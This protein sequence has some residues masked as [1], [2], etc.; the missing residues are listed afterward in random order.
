MT[1]Q[2]T[3]R[4]T[5]G[6]ICFFS[7][8]YAPS[9][10]AQ[11]NGEEPGWEEMMLN[12]DYNFFEIQDAFNKAWDGKPY[13]S[14]NGYK[15]FKRWEYWI[16]TLVDENG[17][18]DEMKTR[19]E[20]ENYLKTHPQNE[21]KSSLTCAN[22]NA[23]GNWTALGPFV[24]PLGNNGIGRVNVVGF[25][26][27]NNNHIWAGTPAGGL[28]EST[29]GGTT[30]TT[31]TDDFQ[32]LGVSDIAIHPTNPD[33]MYI[34]TGDNDHSDTYAFGLLKSIDA[35][36][37]WTTTSLNVGN[38]NLMHRLLMN[39]DDPDVLLV[40]TSNTV[41]KSTDAG[42]TWTN[43]MSDY[44]RHMEFKPG[45]PNIV[46]AT[47]YADGLFFR[48]TDCGSTWTMTSL[49]ASAVDVERFG[50]GV[51]ADDANS[52]F[53][54]GADDDPNGSNDFV[55]LYKS[56]DSGASFTE[57]AVTTPPSLG[58][59][60]WYD[61]TFAVSPMDADEMYAGGVGFYK[62]SDGGLTW[63]SASS[64][65]GT[66]VH[67][68]HHFAGYQPGTSN[69]YVGCD[70]GVFTTPDGASNWTDLSN[71]LTITQYYRLGSSA[72]NPDL[73]LCG[74][75]DNGTHL[76]E[77]GVWDHVNGGDGME[78][79]IDYSNED[80]MFAAYQYGTIRK[81]T[82]GGNNFSTVIS[83]NTTGEDG[84]WVT[85]YVQD[86]N[87]P[88]IMYAGFESIWKSTDNGSNWTNVSGNL[89]SGTM[90]HIAIAPSNSDY[91]YVTNYS[92]TWKSTD[93]GATWNTI[94]HPGGT[95]RYMAIHP[96][97]P[98]TLW[99]ARSNDVYKST[100][101][102][103]SWVNVSGTLPNIPMRT[104]VYQNNT[105]D[106][107]YVGTEVGV[108]YTEVTM[109]DWVLFSDDLP[110]VRVDELQIHDLTGRIRAATFG[111]GLW[112]SDLYCTSGFVCNNILQNF[113]YAEGFEVDLGLW[114]Q[115]TTDDFDWTR[116]MGATPSANT[117]PTSAYEGNYYIY[118]EASGNTNNEASLLSPCINLFNI[119]NPTLYFAYHLYGSQIGS[120]E[121]EITDDFGDTW[122]T[123]WSTSGNQGNAWVFTSADLSAYSNSTVLV[124]FNATIN[125]EEGDIALDNFLIQEGCGT[126]INTFPYVESFE[127][128]LGLWGQSTADDIDW[129]R[130]MGSTTSSGTGP[131]NAFDG[132]YYLYT[133]A[134]GEGDGFPSKV[135]YLN[136]PC[137]DLTS[138]IAPELIF[139]YH[140]LGTSMG[141][142]EV[143]ISTDQ[144]FTWSAPIWSLSGSQG[145]N[146]LS[147]TVDI[148]AY[149]GQIVKFRFKG[150]TGTSWSS[151]MAIDRVEIEDS[152]SP[153][154]NLACL[155]S[156]TLTVNTTQVTITDL[157][158]EN[159]GIAN[160]GA[161]DIGFYL[162]T[163]QIFTVGDNL[164]GTQN[165][166]S[167]NIGASI[168]TTFNV[169]VMGMGITPGDYFVGFIIDY[170]DV[171]SET[172][173]GDNDDCNFASPIV[174]VP[175]YCSG[176]TTLTGST[177]DLSDG[178]GN[179]LDYLNNSNC[180]WFINPPVG[181]TSIILT[182]G[183]FNL[184]DGVDFVRVYEGNSGIAPLLG[185]F[186][187][188]TLPPAVTANGNE[189]FVIF[190]SN[191]SNTAPGFDAS[192][193]TTGCVLPTYTTAC[194]SNDY[195][196]DF[197]FDTFSNLGTGCG[198][199]GANYSDYTGT[200]P[201]IQMGNSYM[202]T[203]GVGSFAQWI[204]VYIDFNQNGNF[205]DPGEFFDLGQ[206]P[207]NGSATGTVTIPANLTKGTSTMRVRTNYSAPL[208]LA[209]GC[210]TGFT[211][212]EIEDYDIVFNCPDDLTLD[213]TPIA[214]GL[215]EADNLLTATG[216][217]PAGGNVTL[218][219]G[220]E[221]D[222][223]LE[224]EVEAGATF[225]IT[226]LSCFGN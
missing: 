224:F 179:S 51:S 89:N 215:Y 155:S 10:F 113:P 87:N 186:T 35:G 15:Q 180:E 103:T 40:S 177:G 101:G 134:S 111:R 226:I 99:A 223:G 79:L 208:T 29:D 181:V 141:T 162:S 173:E 59:Q 97:D 159:N 164:I 115:P 56:T 203:V 14:G 50:I 130:H 94:T 85:P 93:G 3:L 214:D 76:L 206:A 182:F 63:S 153:K 202:V 17:Y 110:N 7:L 220:N 168:T 189:M 199:P 68:D 106:A 116:Q 64:G 170:L 4:F 102:G 27:T 216:T 32:S 191:A 92:T 221:V 156:G 9:S 42:V 118:A 55:G 30:W 44:F 83:Q 175:D 213:T 192:Y 37:T 78:C 222:L 49:P 148:S 138:T 152:N 212:G 18:Y 36:V 218:Q 135:A 95:N 149:N 19:Q 217:I 69:L 57:V 82:N 74:S 205:T 194:T 132:S 90:R 58:S 65:G 66:F 86:P 225:E 195:I 73:V 139:A 54:L 1:L 167:L 100:D 201:S 62:S 124:R 22:P 67:V 137:F 142:L 193:T 61:W 31:N 129:T 122:A 107:L 126:P 70:G 91:I 211:W 114:E 157:M 144:G 131:S 172:N 60:Q 71:G 219:T 166:A 121:I 84:A 77:A 20:F 108:Y 198:N 34:A 8:F 200:G 123:I 2:K 75:Q 88:N 45:D 158:V 109:G 190:T 52:V 117:G 120:L 47:T 147:A 28:W 178:S 24:E 209:D 46:Y 104:I 160:A 196:D 184:E 72:T 127:S 13:V 53:I 145:G 128:G 197:T 188:S 33:I 96:T 41:Y 23:N 150:T 38:F 80:N 165:V 98:N 154:P 25:H 5:V 6:F 183:S 39:P 187:G 185:E 12:P 146:W 163:D 210:A 151:D 125:G 169:D 119:N 48:S 133:E 204:G 26:P 81:S 43:V 143:E 174:T 207:V 112:E 21:I 105:N 140:M 161:F 16:E 171:V 176:L 11:N 136:S